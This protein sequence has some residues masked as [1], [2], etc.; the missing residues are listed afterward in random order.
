MITRL[1]DIIVV[2][3]SCEAPEIIIGTCPG[4][5]VRA[6]ARSRWCLVN[7][8][9]MPKHTL[10]YFV[11]QFHAV[12]SSFDHKMVPLF[13]S[14]WMAAA[15]RSTVLNCTRHCSINNCGACMPGQLVYVFIKSSL[16]TSPS[17]VDRASTCRIHDFR[18]VYVFDHSH[19]FHFT[20]VV[21]FHLLQVVLL[22]ELSNLNT[23]VYFFSPLYSLW[24]S[25]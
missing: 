2:A 21:L 11:G 14:L 12:G 24:F 23:N 22:F 16:I 6:S 18:G 19:R 7:K 8:I 17:D 5:T 13:I 25:R 1:R 20:A 9:H 3:H 4:E 15:L 10:W